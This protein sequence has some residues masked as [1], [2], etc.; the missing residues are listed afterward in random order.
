MALPN[1]HRNPTPDERDERIALPLDPEVALRAL[2]QVKP[3]SDEND[4]H[5]TQ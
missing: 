3:D 5:P 2:L 4:E 1:Q